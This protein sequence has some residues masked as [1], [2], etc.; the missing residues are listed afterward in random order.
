MNIT[1]QANSASRLAIAAREAVSV[2]LPAGAAVHGVGGTLWLTQEGD[3]RDHVLAAGTTFCTDRAG[4]VVLSAIDGGAVALVRD[5][6]PAHCVP[7][8]VSIDSLRAL[9]REAELAKARYIASVFSRAAER[10]RDALRHGVRPERDGSE[11]EG[12]TADQ[13]RGFVRS[14]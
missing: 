11:V 2:E 9:T 5:K 13:F 6:A 4:R 8:T 7:G 12:R 10:L 3:Q 14:H 1:S